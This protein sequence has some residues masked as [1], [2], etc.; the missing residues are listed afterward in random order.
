LWCPRL[1]PSLILQSASPRD[2]ATLHYNRARARY[3]LGQHCAAIDDCTTAL[4]HD[5]SYRNALAQRAECYM[6]LFDFE[7]AGR[8]FGGLL[9][10]DASDRQWARRLQD[11]RGMREMSHYGVLGVKRDA[12]GGTLKRAYRSLCLRWHPDKHASTAEDAMRAN[13]AFRVSA[14]LLL[15]WRTL[16][17]NGSPCG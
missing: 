5:G 7:R 3:R 10:S 6:S 9:D 8:D 11:A 17:C 15:R 14:V 2:L 1:L 16:R 4:R 12:E 13:A